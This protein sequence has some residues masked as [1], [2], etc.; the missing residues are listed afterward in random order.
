MVR[1]ENKATTNIGQAMLA[2]EISAS[3]M[4]EIKPMTKAAAAGEGKP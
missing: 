2:A 1:P 3:V 4:M